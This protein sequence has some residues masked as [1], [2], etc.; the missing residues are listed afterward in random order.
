[1]DTIYIIGIVV[2]GILTIYLGIAHYKSQG[3]L[4]EDI[5]D[6]VEEKV[7]DAIEIT[8]DFLSIVELEDNVEKNTN[9]VLN[10]THDIVHFVA[11][12]LTDKNIDKK[13]ASIDLVNAILDELKVDASDDHKKLIKLIVDNYFQQLEKSK[14]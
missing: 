14:K 3:K 1:M 8:K 10:V 13:Q 2:L 12:N 5:V 11:S 6:V 4:T 9:T 7:D